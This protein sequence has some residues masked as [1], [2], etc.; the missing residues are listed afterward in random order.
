MTQT[1]GIL[2]SLHTHILSF[3][4]FI[5]MKNWEKAMGL[6]SGRFF[7][8]TDFQSTSSPPRL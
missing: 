5:W 7:S 1:N 6:L 4:T 2:A 8:H 3:H